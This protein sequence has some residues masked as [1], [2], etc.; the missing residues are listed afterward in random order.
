MFDVLSKS[1]ITIVIVTHEQ[2]VGA[3]AKKI[4][5]MKDGRIL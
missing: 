4:L 3:R 1:G 5:R 2:D